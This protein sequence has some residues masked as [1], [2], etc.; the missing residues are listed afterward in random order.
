MLLPVLTESNGLR[1]STWCT[2]AQ[3]LWAVAY[4]SL[5]L[6]TV[7][8]ISLVYLTNPVRHLLGA[9]SCLPLCVR[10]VP[11]MALTALAKVCL[12]TLFVSDVCR[13]VRRFFQHWFQCRC[14]LSFWRWWSRSSVLR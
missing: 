4:A 5:P 11:V 1:A 3:V 7:F 12:A 6:A 10:S 9:T 13:S 8:F 14:S 2:E